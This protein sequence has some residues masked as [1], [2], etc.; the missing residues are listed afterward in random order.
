MDNVFL[1]VLT[2]FLAG[3]AGIWKGIPIGMILK[4][5]PMSIAALTALG[6][7]T[8]VLILY[9]FGEFA[10]QWVLKKWSKE[11]LERRKGKFSSIMD[12]YGIIGLGIICPGIFGPITSII[13]GLLIVKQ[14]SRLMPYLIIG[15]ILW[16]FV[17]T[18]FAVSGFNMLNNLR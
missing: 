9:Y 10:K 14:T 17:L 6:S 13:V 1:K 15:I 5:H 18:W 4:S 8:T 7:I 16:S 3:M 12:K 2:I 11:K